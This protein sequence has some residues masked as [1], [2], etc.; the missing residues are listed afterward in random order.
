MRVFQARKVTVGVGVCVCVCVCARVCVRTCVCVSEIDEKR[1][2]CE[3]VISN[4][5]IWKDKM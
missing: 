3:A 5:P 2:V 1:K 4:I